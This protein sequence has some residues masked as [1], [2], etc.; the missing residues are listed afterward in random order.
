[1]KGKYY[2]IQVPI[3]DF[4]DVEQLVN[5]VL[6]R[7]PL[8]T[9]GSAAYIALNLMDKRMQDGLPLIDMASFNEKNRG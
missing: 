5:R 3:A 9:R 6:K 8:L 1:V 4:P 2:T 7:N